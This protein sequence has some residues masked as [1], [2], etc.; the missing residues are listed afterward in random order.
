LVEQDVNKLTGG[1]RPIVASEAG[2]KLRLI[3]GSF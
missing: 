3:L 2:S 1:C